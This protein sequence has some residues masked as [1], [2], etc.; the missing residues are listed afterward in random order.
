[1][2][3]DE[4]TRE[5]PE[6]K[7]R[8]SNMQPWE[9]TLTKAGAN[10]RRLVVTKSDDGGGVVTK[11]PEDGTEATS[12]EVMS[13]PAAT[14]TSLLEVL[15]PVVEKLGA[16]GQVV[17]A[18]PVDEAAGVPAQLL[19]LLEAAGQQLISLAQGL[20]G[21]PETDPGGSGEA[22]PVAAADGD[23]I[24]KAEGLSDNTLRDAITAALNVKHSVN[25][26]TD[27]EARPWVVDVFV[28]DSTAVY[29]MNSEYYQVTYSRDGANVSITG[30]PT[31]MR[32]T[33]VAADAPESTEDGAPGAD[34]ANS[35]DASEEVDKSSLEGL[36]KRLEAA[37]ARIEKTDV[38]GL[39]VQALVQK[40]AEEQA[41]NLTAE[42]ITKALAGLRAQ[43]T[44]EVITKKSGE[45]SENKPAA[46]D[47]NA[48]W[49]GLN[50]IGASLNEKQNRD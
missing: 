30:E 13:L 2:P 25:E 20:G 18:A 33:Y 16:L 34:V 48:I 32:V 45:G 28:D 43:A 38:P 37:V 21:E 24:N 9:V 4:T 8:L 7:S 27:Y 47:P 3:S 12:D 29:R 50:D 5:R 15:A 49:A 1:M 46:A 19:E 10:L 14:K 31:K 35:A 17:S 39:V 40:S 6:A 41:N 26:E 11:A 23:G 36:T 42:P 22:D 44:D